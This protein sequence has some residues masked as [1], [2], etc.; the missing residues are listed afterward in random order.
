MTFK[1]VIPG[2]NEILPENDAEKCIREISAMISDIQKLGDFGIEKWRV[3]ESD[4]MEG[5]RTV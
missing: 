3:K 1:K 2:F 4:E 5:K